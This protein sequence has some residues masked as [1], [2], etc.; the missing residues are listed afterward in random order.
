MVKQGP[1]LSTWKLWPTVRQKTWTNIISKRSYRRS[2]KTR[3]WTDCFR[4]EHLISRWK[5][6]QVDLSKVP[7]LYNSFEDLSWPSIIF[8][9]YHCF[10][11][12]SEEVWKI[13]RD[14]LTEIL[15][16][17]R[18]ML[19]DELEPFCF[20]QRFQQDQ[21]FSQDEIQ[22][23]RKHGSRRYRAN[24]FLRLL[25]AKGDPAMEVFMDEMRRRGDSYMLQQL[26]P[27][28]PS[29]QCK[30]IHVPENARFTTK[31][32]TALIPWAFIRDI[33]NAL[34]IW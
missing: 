11:P 30:G 20:L 8:L 34:I 23:I 1:W 3:K 21:I 16:D 5:P 28:S 6:S 25:Q 4:S 17:N 12:S 31:T 32:C 15:T 29:T 13:H 19:E 14:S 9:I 2:S 27:S 33:L 22:S 18:P 24:E 26:I 7:F 10:F